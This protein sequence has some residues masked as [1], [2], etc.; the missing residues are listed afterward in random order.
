M[1]FLYDGALQTKANKMLQSHSQTEMK[2]NDDDEY[3]VEAQ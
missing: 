3:D 1:H 2:W